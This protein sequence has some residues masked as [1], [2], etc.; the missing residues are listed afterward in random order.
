MAFVQNDLLHVLLN[1]DMAN[2]EIRR[3]GEPVPPL[4]GGGEAL[5]LEFKADGTSKAR[6][7]VN[8]GADVATVLPERRWTVAPNETVMLAGFKLQGEKTFPLSVQ[9]EQEMKR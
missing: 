7:V 4:D 1:D 3:S 9:F 8:G 6:S 5:L 2:E